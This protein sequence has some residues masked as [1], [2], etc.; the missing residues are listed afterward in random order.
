MAGRAADAAG[1]ASSIQG[2]CE[3]AS[4]TSMLNPGSNFDEGA[5]PLVKRAELG[6]GLI[7][8]FE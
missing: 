7:P 3:K 6:I 2:T 1:P 5:L 8:A 4:V